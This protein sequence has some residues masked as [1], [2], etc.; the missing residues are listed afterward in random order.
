MSKQPCGMMLMRLSFVVLV[1]FLF[2]PPPVRAET[3]PITIVFSS[4]WPTSYEYLW[5]PTQNFAKKVE[6]R[7]NGRVKFKLYHSAQLYDGKAEFGALER[8]D[9]DMASPTDLYHTKIIPEL[10]IT[11]LPFLYDSVESLQKILDAGL[12]DLGINQ[13]LAEHNIIALSASAGDPFQFYS[14]DT[15]T[16]SPEQVKGKRWAV[17]GATHEQ[18][19]KLMGGEPVAM[20]SGKLY[21]SFQRGE[22]DGG[23]RPL[24]TG[25][26]RKLFEVVDYLTITDFAFFTSILVINKQKWES[27]PPDIQQIMRQAAKERSQETLQMVRDY[28]NQSTSFFADKGVKVVVLKPEEK[29]R[30][31]KAMAPVYEWWLNQV[32]DGQKYLD[33]VKQQQN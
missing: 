18:A 23:A 15:A 6:E 25:Q 5:I 33:F 28:I 12:F 24:L 9:I 31:R 11:S 32:Q 1:V 7:S 16:I 20:S 4:F 17:A 26:G 14:N 2:L 13:K 8:G 30:F 19:I 29:D 22:I 27:L 21:M 3:E 10:G